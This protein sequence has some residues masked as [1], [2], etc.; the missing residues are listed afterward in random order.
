MANTHPTASSVASRLTDEEILKLAELCF[1]EDHS[2]EEDQKTAAVLRDYVRLR[3]DNAKLRIDADLYKGA[4]ENW[5]RKYRSA[6]ARLEAVVKECKRI[7]DETF[8]RSINKVVAY[9]TRVD[10]A[11]DAICHA[12][13]RAARGEGGAK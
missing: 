12:I 3:N 13:L 4:S 6:E 2:V 11:S 10:V 9:K 7:N 5:E 1:F 8:E